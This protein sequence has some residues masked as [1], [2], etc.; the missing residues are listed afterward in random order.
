MF[1]IWENSAP[2]PYL[3]GRC[4][5]AR[6]VAGL[7]AT[8]VISAYHYSSLNLAHGDLYSKHLHVIKF[9]SDFRQV[10]DFLRFPPP[11]ELTAII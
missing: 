3:G 2:L 7:T 8:Y 11:I 6:M 4:G 1:Y 10:D 9:I 5:R